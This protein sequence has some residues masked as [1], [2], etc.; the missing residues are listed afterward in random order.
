MWLTLSGFVKMHNYSK[1]LYSYKNISN[2][3]A[4]V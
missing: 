2:G 1:L 3:L 4:W